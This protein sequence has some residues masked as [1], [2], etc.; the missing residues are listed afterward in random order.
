MQFSVLLLIVFSMELAAG[1]AGY[2]LRRD[3]ESMLKNT[4]NS[5]MYACATD[6]KMEET[7]NIVQHEVHPSHVSFVL[8]PENSHVKLEHLNSR[9]L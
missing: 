4:A 3:V 2:I 5:T 7:W 1:I 8:V 9:Y 6:P